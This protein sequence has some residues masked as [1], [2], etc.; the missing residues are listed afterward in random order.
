M[1]AGDFLDL[2]HHFEARGI[3]QTRSETRGAQGAHT[4]VIAAGRDAVSCQW[5]QGLSR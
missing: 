5:R 4:R 3:G 1:G 2:V